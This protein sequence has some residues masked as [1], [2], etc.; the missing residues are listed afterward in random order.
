MKATL[1]LIVK[2]KIKMNKIKVLIEQLK[3]K[4]NKEHQIKILQN[5]NTLLLTRYK[6]KID[7]NFIIHPIQVEGYYY[8]DRHF[9]DDTVHKSELQKN[10]FGKLYFHRKGK[11]KSSKI[12]F[13]RSGID[14]CLSDNDNYFYSA[15]IRSARINNEE[16]II[17]GPQR[18][19]QRI[20]RYICKNDNLSSLSIGNNSS[21]SEFEK[22][23]VV[24]VNSETREIPILIH[25]S[26]IGLKKGSDYSALKLRSL[27][28]LRVSKQ[29]EKDVLFYMED[30]NIDPTPD[31]IRNI[32]GYSPNWIIEQLNSIKFLPTTNNE[33]LTGNVTD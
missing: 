7:E 11:N 2:S 14:I 8:D 21:L 1:L 12:L 20:Y 10:K 32:L 13:T 29:K 16:S 22:N 9:K 26:R 31:N 33:A 30:N 4:T 24:L 25:S 6:L 28:E 5:I 17:D 19:A 23:N 3:I 27:T 15:L 18:L